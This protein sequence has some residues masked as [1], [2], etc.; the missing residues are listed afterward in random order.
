MMR[1][2]NLVLACL[3]LSV[4]SGYAA[5]APVSAG[6]LAEMMQRARNSDGFEA[7][8]NV[9]V[10]KAN[11]AHPAPLKLAVVGQFTTDRQRL[12]IRGIAPESVRN[13]FYAAER[14][15]DGRIRAVTYGDKNTSQVAAADPFGALFDSGLVLADM[16]TPWWSWPRQSLEGSAR[17]NGRECTKVHSAGEE[18]TGDIRLVE[19]CID[20]QAK[21]SLRTRL[22]DNRHALLRTTSVE[23]AMRK[24]G[25]NALLAKKLVITDAARMRTDIEVYAGDEQYEISAETFAVLDHL[26]RDEQQGTK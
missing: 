25:G 4:A 11:G 20:P 9:F 2:A 16:F 5:D 24:E 26:I 6:T 14:G 22:F 21:L 1:A 12:L 17:I 23:S 7:R 13:R 8:L 10:T 3:L 18:K 15:H 19:S